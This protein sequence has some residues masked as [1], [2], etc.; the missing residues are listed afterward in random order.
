M[1]V[2]GLILILVSAGSLVAVL[3]SGTDDK[4]MLFGSVSMPTLVVFLAGAA[5]LLIFIMGLEL[6]RSGVRRAN[7]NRKTKKKLR[8]LEKREEKRSDG[9]PAA[10]ATEPAST[11]R[12]DTRTDGD[13]G[14]TQPIRTS[15]DEP[16]QSPPPPSR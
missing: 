13:P 12:T 4:A 16:Y 11:T 1:L 8:T 6:V 5:A 2:L 15:G 7:Q 14:T 10:Q 9:T 3:A